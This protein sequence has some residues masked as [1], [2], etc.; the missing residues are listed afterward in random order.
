MKVIL[1]L[2]ISLLLTNTVIGQKFSGLSEAVN[3]S[4]PQKSATL[5]G[6]STPIHFK[7]RQGDT[8]F[9]VGQAKVFVIGKQQKTLINVPEA[10]TI[11]S[12][13]NEPSTIPDLEN[14][15][16]KYYSLIIGINDY[17]FDN[18]R[19][20]DLNKAVNDANSLQKILIEN[21][22]FQIDKSTILINPNRQEIIKELESLADR[23]TL[24]DNL[25]IFYAGHGVWDERINIGYWLPSDAKIE[26][27]STWISNSTIRDYIAGI[28]SKHTLLITD[29]CFSGS[30]FKMRDI[31]LSDYG[32]SNLY[33][34]PSRKAMTSGTLTA[35]PDESKFMQYFIKR[36]IDTEG[37]YISARQLFYGLETAVLNNTN[38]VPQFGV[39]QDTGDEGGDFI[40][41][42]KQKN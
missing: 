7:I 22:N 39:I 13:K 41:I 17:Q 31:D 3:F 27:K 21:F 28:N 34:L 42:R 8:M 14:N 15:L 16:P 4:I 36:L 12:N 18:E 24:K 6:V 10:K 9:G 11:K 38:T 37:K 35:V 26:D 33:R 29:A 25:L 19:L 40:F 30:I 20:R 32:M 2:A 5:I 1:T 23:I